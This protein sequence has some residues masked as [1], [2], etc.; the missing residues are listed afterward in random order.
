MIS[1]ECILVL[2]GQ[3][4]QALA[5]TRSLGLAGH[6]VY[7]AS[8]GRWPLAS[9]SR[10]CTDTFRLQEETVETYARL[11]AWSHERGITM[12]LP[13]TER[14]CTL[15][16]LER[17][18]W[19]T[20]GITVGC[21]PE[22]LLMLAFD[23]VKTLKLAQTCG[24]SIPP[25][26]VPCS[27]E[28]CYEAARETGFPCVIKPRYSNLWDGTRFIRGRGTAYADS[29]E[30]LKKAVLACKQDVYWPLIQGYV[31]GRGEGVF[32][33]CDHGE[34]V[35]WFAHKRLRDVRPTGSGSSLRQSVALK[36]R[37]QEPARHLL[38]TLNW[39]GPAMVEFRDDGVASPFLME[40]NGRFWG[41]LQ[42]AID[43]GVDF[44]ELWYQ[45]IRN[46]RVEPIISYEQGLT[47]RWLWGDV[48]RFLYIL[49]GPPTGY[50]GAYPARRE[51]LAEL[52]GK[53]PAG[54]RSETWRKNDPGPAVGEWIQGLM[55]LSSRGFS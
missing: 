32:A 31:E 9:W 52:F 45:L 34:V 24:V 10:H 3:T 47:L 14:S 44:P 23:K 12:V 15:C 54:T 41:S 13:L 39:H 38:A 55:E 20:H 50:T 27:L 8:L 48:K 16:N 26:H 21:G 35:A 19:E 17:S 22:D 2:D 11:R 1:Q 29:E 37:L 36:P 46:E 5:C 40:V 53:T 49:K 33:L 30:T 51:G 6:T 28:E 7:V 4:T 43:A 42:L 25:T 18:A